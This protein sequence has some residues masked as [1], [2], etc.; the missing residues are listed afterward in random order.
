MDGD[1]IKNLV[2]VDN[3]GEAAALSTYHVVEAVRVNPFNPHKSQ[4]GFTT[5]PQVR[6]DRELFERGELM[7]NAKSF[8]TQ[9]GILRAK[10]NILIPKI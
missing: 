9:L 7:V 3:I 10:T 5:L 2:W 4:F 6:D 1:E 8:Y